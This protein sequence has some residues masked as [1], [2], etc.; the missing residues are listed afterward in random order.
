V[1]EAEAAGLEPEERA[2]WVVFAESRHLP[3]V[4]AWLRHLPPGAP[5][6][7]RVPEGLRFARVAREGLGRLLSS[8]VRMVADGDR[9]VPG[10]VHLLH[11]NQ[12]PWI[13]HN[14]LFPRL[15]E[16]ALADPPG[17]WCAQMTLLLRLAASTVSLRV[18]LPEVGA[19]DRLEFLAVSRGRHAV[20]RLSAA[21]A[22]TAEGRNVGGVDDEQ[23]RAG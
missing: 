7:L 10:H 20:Y 5:I 14:G 8:P 4:A 15:R 21:A 23:C 12:V 18:V 16:V 13:E 9:L 11:D 6:V 19:L 1:L 17:S 3:A 2:P 22:G